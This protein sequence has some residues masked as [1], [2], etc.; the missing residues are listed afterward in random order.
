MPDADPLIEKARAWTQEGQGVVLVTVTETWGS[1]PC[2][3]GSRMV[4]NEKVGFEGS[5]SGGCIESEVISESLEIIKD[6]G[7]RVLEYGVSDEISQQAGLSCGGT[8]HVLAEKLDDALLAEL[9]GERPFA[10]V[11]DLES[12]DWAVVRPGAGS[13]QGSGGASG[14]L[15]LSGPVLDAAAASLDDEQARTVEE[16]GDAGGRRVFI[17]PYTPAWRLFIVGAVRIAQALIPMA[18]AAGFEVTVID[19]RDAFSSDERFPDIAVIRKWPDK[20]LADLIPDGHSAIVTLIHNAEHDDRALGVAVRSEAFY[21]GA[22]GSRRTH[23]KRTE[24]L[25]DAG[26]TKDEI[27]RIHAPVGLDL[28]ARAPGEIAV[29]I[30]AQIVAA[31]R[32]RGPGREGNG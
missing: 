14:S 32:G 6:G 28:G 29:A 25:E 7:H 18:V 31:K 26:Y 5:V 16:E 15:P 23:A 21:I 8:I 1:S 17:H 19:P 12:G 11:I 3:A 20:A 27:A 4:I 22:L 2:P 10:R 24:R 13:D 30:I 9:S